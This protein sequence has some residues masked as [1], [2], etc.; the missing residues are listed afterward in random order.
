MPKRK[1]AVADCETDPFKINRVPKPFL[2]GYYDGLDYLEFATTK[3]FI[4]HVQELNIIVYAHNGGKFDWHFIKE[5]I[6]NDIKIMV[7]NG[8]LS[9]FKIGACEFRDSYNLMPVP[10]AAYQKTE[11]DYNIFEIEERNKPHNAKLISDYLKDDCIY[12]Y[13]LVSAFIENYGMNLTLASSAM[14]FWKKHFYSGQAFNSS[15]MFFEEIKEYYYGGRVECFAKG[16][17]EKEF[18]VFDIKSA[19]PFA[20]THFHPWGYKIKVLD[21]LPKHYKQ[22]FITL[23]CVSK[24]AFPYREKSG[25]AFPNDKEKR[26]YTI[27]GWEL[28]T[29]KKYKLISDVEIIKVL[30]FSEQITFGEYV[31]HFFELKEKERNGDKRLYLLAKLFLNSLYGKF[32]ANPLKYKDYWTVPADEIRHF[33]ENTGFTFCAMVG[34]ET[35][36]MTQDLPE[37][38]MRF[39]NVATA[40]SITGFVRAYLLEYMTKC[41]NV[42][43]CD[44][45]SIAHYGDK[46]IFPTG[47]IL[48]NWDNE[49]DFSKA[50]IAGKKLYA[51]FYKKPKKGKDGKM[52]KSKIASKGVKLNEKQI[53]SV[54]Q[55]KKVLYKSE[56]PTFSIKAGVNF[57]SRIVQLT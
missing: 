48:G 35:A 38:E 24:G 37:E 39:Y 45:D 16:V 10:L 33:Q 49:G 4:E 52:I 51:F 40:A 7:I 31:N 2:W 28:F 50:A 43:Y 18:S 12:L 21:K 25:L 17:I 47:D 13:E 54:A 23:R 22:C 46:S 11:I 20:M 36:L 34:K 44:T 56:A 42:L 32:A 14:K 6:P 27:T 8:R 5:Y 41:G 19:Y 3:E 1:I 9:S 26:E 53:L 55:G 30:Q 29:A 57:I 15:R